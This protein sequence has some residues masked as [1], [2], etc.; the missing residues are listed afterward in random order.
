MLS[1]PVKSDVLLRAL[2]VD[3]RG[4]HFE[5]FA[6]QIGQRRTHRTCVVPGNFAPALT[7]LTA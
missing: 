1:G 3:Q 2:L 6:R 7:M 4:E 5:L